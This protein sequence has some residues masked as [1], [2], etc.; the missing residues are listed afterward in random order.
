MTTDAISVPEL[1][2][3]NGQKLALSLDFRF[4]LYLTEFSLVYRLAG[5][6][7]PRL[8]RR[9]S[10]S[11]SVRNNPRSFKTGRTRS[12]KSLNPWGK[13]EA[14]IMNPSA[15]PASN[16]AC[17]VSATCSGVPMKGLFGV[18]DRSAI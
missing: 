14:F 7:N 15:A 5:F 10:C 12:T 9:V 2:T 13:T 16:Q 3:S 17:M 1:D 6:A 8:P 18:V 4:K 11:Y